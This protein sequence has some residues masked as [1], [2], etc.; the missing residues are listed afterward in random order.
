MEGRYKGKEEG[1]MKGRKE[2]RM[3][4]SYDMDMMLQYHR[5]PRG[6]VL[7]GGVHSSMKKKKNFQT[8]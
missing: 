7:G 6:A 3:K 5:K 2:R 1:W 4:V 8:S